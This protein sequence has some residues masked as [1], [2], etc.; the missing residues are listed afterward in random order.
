MSI[1]SNAGDS[2]SAEIADWSR[3]RP[4]QFW[5]PGRKLLRS[6]RR[7]QYWQRRGGLVAGIFCRILV[8]RYRFWS[9]VTGADI[10]LNCQIGGGL[11]IPHPNGI[12][13]HP[14]AK[15]G[16]NCLVFQQVTV[17]TRDHYGPPTIGGHVDIG[18]GA[19]VLGGI[20]IGDHAR[21][22]ANAVVTKD[23]PTGAKAVG[24]I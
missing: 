21:I 10:P 16:V 6:I 15:I 23:V 18:A 8:V 17:G 14:E 11:L 20:T 3:E 1:D 2:V 9:I 12:V 24:T 4:Q 13:I 22:G 7:Y 19:K 5:D